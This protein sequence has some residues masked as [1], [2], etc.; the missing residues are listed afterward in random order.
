VRS[1]LG[2][3]RARDLAWLFGFGIASVTLA[4]LPAEFAQPY[5]AAVLGEDVRD[6]GRTPLLAGVLVGANTFVAG[7]AAGVSLR[8]RAW[9]GLGGA[10]LTALSWQVAVLAAMAWVVH[11]AVAL[12]LLTRSCLPAITRVLVGVELAP[13]LPTS[14]RASYLSLDS[15]AG[16]LG[17]AG[18]LA[19]LAWVTGSDGTASGAGLAAVLW[20]SVAIGVL[21]LAS[22]VATRPTALGRGM[23]QESDS[24]SEVPGG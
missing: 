23:Q 3:L 17:Y 14:L 7:W 16:R 22:L 9:L 18:V 20:A 2:V 12:L 4:H 13:R 21:G 5:L 1:L 19:G 8:L 24:P 11:P 10:L 15:L 6:V